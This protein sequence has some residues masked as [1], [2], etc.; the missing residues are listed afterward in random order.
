MMKNSFQFLTIADSV[1]RFASEYLQNWPRENVDHNLRPLCCDQEGACGLME[2]TPQPLRLVGDDPARAWALQQMMEKDAI[3]MTLLDGNESQDCGSATA[4]IILF[5]KALGREVILFVNSFTKFRYVP[6]IPMLMSL[7]FC[8]IRKQHE[9]G[10]T[11]YR[12]SETDAVHEAFRDDIGGLLGQRCSIVSSEDRTCVRYPQCKITHVLLTGCVNTSTCQTQSPPSPLQVLSISNHHHPSTSAHLHTVQLTH[13]HRHSTNNNTSS[14]PSLCRLPLVYLRFPRASPCSRPCFPSF[15]PV[16]LSRRPCLFCLSLCVLPA[17]SSTQVDDGHSGTLD[18]RPIADWLCCRALSHP[19]S[20]SAGP[21]AGGQRQGQFEKAEAHDWHRHPSQPC[22]GSTRWTPPI[23]GCSTQ[24]CAAL[25]AGSSA[26]DFLSRGI[27]HVHLL[28]DVGVR[29]KL[30]PCLSPVGKVRSGVKQSVVLG[31]L[32]SAIS[33]TCSWSASIFTLSDFSALAR[34]CSW[35]CTV[36][37]GCFRACGSRRVRHIRWPASSAALGHSLRTYT[38][39]GYG[40]VQGSTQPALPHATALLDTSR[41]T[42]DPTFCNSHR[43]AAARSS[44]S[45]SPPQLHGASSDGKALREAASASVRVRG[46]ASQL[47]QLWASA[48]RLFLA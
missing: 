36:A 15:F 18:R 11:R 22:S 44:P 26:F 39:S 30:F 46:P 16:F 32:S 13:L 23:L 29:T 2:I 42:D 14:P 21:E 28:E 7:V 37:S 8:Q 48:S 38:Q 12:D 35:V 41:L 43:G 47:F 40:A 19:S 33:P 1:K 27:L 6:V 4:C 31:P 10:S 20:A 25:G 9:T 3:N 24:V 17:F 45:W 5:C 34:R